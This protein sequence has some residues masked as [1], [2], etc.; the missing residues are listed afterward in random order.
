MTKPFPWVDC[1]RGEVFTIPANGEHDHL[2]AIPPQGEGD[3]LNRP[4]WLACGAWLMVFGY[5]AGFWLFYSG[6]GE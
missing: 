3:P 1:V 6:C 4:R 2:G 5:S